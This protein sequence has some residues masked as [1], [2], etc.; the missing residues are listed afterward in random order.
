[1][2]KMRSTTQFIQLAQAIHGNRYNYSETV[3][4]GANAKVRIGCPVHGSFLQS[5]TN[6]TQ[7]HGCRHCAWD[8]I[9]DQHR[10]TTK[11]FIKRAQDVH[12]R[13]YRYTNTRYQN[14]AA[15]LEVECPTH[16]SFTVVAGR[17]LKGSG[18]PTCYA[19]VKVAYGT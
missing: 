16:G 13:R 11:E 1:M 8:V 6:H 4:T 15:H 14:Y 10:N 12:G 2:P 3:Y 18:C 17:H 9:G 5:P 7:G 19:L